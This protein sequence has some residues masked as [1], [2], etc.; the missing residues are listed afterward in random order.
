MRGRAIPDQQDALTF[1]GVCCGELVEKELHTRGVESRQHEPEDAPRAGMSRC[2]EPEPFV[3]LI[4]DGLG[5][6]SNG[7]PDTAE[8]GLE[9]EAS[10]V[11]APDFDFLRRV[12]FLKGLRLKFY[13]FLN[14]ACSSSEARRLFAGRGT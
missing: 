11:F 8:D 7:C 1:S 3:A 12:C 14:A 4:N 2:I 6:L 5:A 10:L 13:L 9:A